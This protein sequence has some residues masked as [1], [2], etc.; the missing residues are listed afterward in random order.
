MIVGSKTNGNKLLFSTKWSGFPDDKQNGAEISNDTDGFKQLMIVGNKSAGGPRKVGVWDEL[1]VHGKLCLNDHCID[2]LPEH[3][4][5]DNNIEIEEATYGGNCNAGLKGNRTDLFKG[6]ANGKK[7]L[8]YVYN[9]QA[10]GGD[11][12]AGCGKD[13]EIKYKCGNESKIFKA[14]PEAGLN[15]RVN[16][17]CS[18]SK[19]VPEHVQ[20]NDRGMIVSSR[21]NDNK[22][23]FSTKWS[24]FPD[25][26]SNGAEISNDTDGFK[27]LMIVG[28][29]SA[30]GP[31][32]VG[33]WDQLDVNGKLNVTDS[34]KTNILHLGEKFRL[35]GVGDR[36]GNDDWLRLFN[37]DNTGYYGG[38]AAG[39]LWAKDALWVQ[40]RNIIDE[41][42]EIRKKLG[43]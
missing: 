13:L 7:E 18:N 21:I 40:N 35:S 43:M 19:E 12:A 22:L 29:K 20:F 26:K 37:K 28:N 23:L 8:N 31:R 34:T 32:K 4:N 3:H 42:N 11:P 25:D 10:T 36:D 2:K 33:V 24:G 14:P 9:Y 15:A 27:Q 17:T 41:I 39:R 38:L 30:G 6:L 16:L 5:E 1:N